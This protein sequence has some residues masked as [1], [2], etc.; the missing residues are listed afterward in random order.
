MFF[1]KLVVS[2]DFAQFIEPVLFDYPTVLFDFSFSI[3]Q[4]H[5]LML[6]LYS[7]KLLQFFL[8]LLYFLWKF[9]LVHFRRRQDIVPP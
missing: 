3:L 9:S 1:H 7:L 5:N 4:G 6:S 8:N 2:S